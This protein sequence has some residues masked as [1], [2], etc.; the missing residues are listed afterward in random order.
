MAA[1]GGFSTQHHGV[2]AIEY[3]IG[4]VS[5]FGAGRAGVRDHTIHHLG[6]YNYWASPLD[7][8]SDDFLLDQRQLLHRHFDTQVAAGYHNTIGGLD[9]LIDAVNGFRLFDFGNDLRWVVDGFDAL[10]QVLNILS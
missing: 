8:L 4:H 2:G 7:A 5:D 6:R 3:S 10:A 1:Y 9:D